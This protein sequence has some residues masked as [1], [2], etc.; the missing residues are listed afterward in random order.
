M[1]EKGTLNQPSAIEN[2]YLYFD[3][4]SSCP[5]DENNSCAAATNN[6]LLNSGR[7]ELHSQVS[8]SATRIQEF[9]SKRKL[10]PIVGT[11]SM[12]L[13]RRKIGLK[14]SYHRM[15]TKELEGLD[16][17]TGGRKDANISG[18]LPLRYLLD[19]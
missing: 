14:L 16:R 2:V 17:R 15:S 13:V 11:T 5:N 6:V 12:K 1:N 18:N 8:K 19:F 7:K 3:E 10:G 9:C 4:E